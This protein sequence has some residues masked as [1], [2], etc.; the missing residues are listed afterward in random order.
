LMLRGARAMRLV[1][2]QSVGGG[3]EAAG[4]A[5]VRASVCRLAC[6]ASIKPSVARHEVGYSAAEWYAFASMDACV[7]GM[8]EQVQHVI[9]QTLTSSPVRPALQIQHLALSETNVP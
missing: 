5:Y 9:L 6:F 4:V 3:G 7:A 2:L 1:S 8:E